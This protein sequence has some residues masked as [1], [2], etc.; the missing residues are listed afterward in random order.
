MDHSAI[1]GNDIVVFMYNENAHMG[2]VAVGEYDYVT[3]RTS[4]SVI[5]RLGHKDDMVAQQVAYSISKATK[6]A[7]CAIVGIHVDNITEAEINQIIENSKEL[8]SEFIS[9]CRQQRLSPK[10]FCSPDEI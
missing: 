4:T 10:W 1:F 5:A 9:V 2:A 6:K 8:V 7:T 3:G